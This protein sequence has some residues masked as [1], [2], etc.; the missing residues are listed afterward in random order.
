MAE[1]AYTRLANDERR[2]RL[3]ELGERLFTE[4]AYSEV[5]MARIAREAGISKALLY[6]YFPSKR[7][8]FLATLASGA[9]EIRRR[10][11][12]A[13]DL[14][15][16]QALMASLEAYLAWIEEHAEGYRKLVQSAAT[17]PEVHDIVEA[18]R[19]AT[20]GRI[21]DGLGTDEPAARAAVRGWLWFVDGVCV[22]WVTE[23]DLE[24]GQVLGLLLGTLY[25]ALTSAGATP[26]LEALGAR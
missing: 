2:R 25:G 15:P 14:P 21:L 9:E 7:D 4:H 24:R 1:P 13:P 8:Y 5:S 16:A 17:D 11:E 10:V 12:P 18:V 22:E 6:H 26:A 23:R 19:H 20:A 3:L